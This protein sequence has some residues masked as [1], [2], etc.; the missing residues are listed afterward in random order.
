[1]E[2]MII[3]AFFWRIGERNSGCLVDYSVFIVIGFF[4]KPII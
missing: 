4:K 1:M 3:N 2:N